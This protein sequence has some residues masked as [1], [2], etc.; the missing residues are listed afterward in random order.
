MSRWEAFRVGSFS[1]YTLGWAALN[2]QIDLSLRLTE[3]LGVFV[4][5]NGSAT[6][7]L[8]MPSLVFSPNGGYA[9][10]GRGG[11]ALRVFRAER[12]RTQVVLRL[13]GAATAGRTLDLLGLFGAI[14]RARSSRPL[15]DRVPDTRYR[16]APGSRPE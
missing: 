16:A 14:L 13:Y 4:E 7:G 8:D 2:E 12:T 10:G 3:W 15:A 5:G 11:V 6:I 1:R 9:Y